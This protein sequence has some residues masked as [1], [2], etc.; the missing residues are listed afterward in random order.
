MSY[1]IRTC[2]CCGLRR[3]QPEMTSTTITTSAGQ[4]RTT[5]SGA[6]LLGAAIGSKSA[7]R[8]VA[9]GI[10]NAGGRQ[11]FNTSTVWHCGGESCVESIR[12]MDQKPG[13]GAG[14]GTQ[15]M[16]KLMGAGGVVFVVL[17]VFANMR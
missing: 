3:P 2:S 11:H 16:L 15:L 8:A 1:T 17:A 5:V 9:R 10:F 4:T 6:T 12:A 7:R 13:F 14:G